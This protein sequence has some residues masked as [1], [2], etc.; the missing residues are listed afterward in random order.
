MAAN[1]TYT[2]G[3]DGEWFFPG[4]SAWTTSSSGSSATITFTCCRT[5]E[6]RLERF[7]TWYWCRYVLRDRCL[8]KVGLGRLCGWL[9]DRMG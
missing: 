9:E 7:A 8:C 2:T 5:P 1:W 3:G 4:D 6:T